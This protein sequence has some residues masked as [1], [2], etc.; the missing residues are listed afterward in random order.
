MM[1]VEP[2]NNKDIWEDKVAQ[3]V[4]KLLDGW[5]L[6]AFEDY[7]FQRE[8]AYYIDPKHRNDL[9]EIVKLLELDIEI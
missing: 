3:I 4:E 6:E 1:E 9:L 5:E 8:L 2:H 7:A